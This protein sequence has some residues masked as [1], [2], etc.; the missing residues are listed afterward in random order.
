MR[1]IEDFGRAIELDPKFAEAYYNRGRAYHAIQ[2]Y[3]RAIEEYG[4]G[5]ELDPEF[6]EV[7]HNRGLAY[8]ELQDYERAIED[9]GCIM[10]FANNA[11]TI[12]LRGTTFCPTCSSE[13]PEGFLSSTVDF[14]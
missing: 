14:G 13:L 5:I 10:H 11:E 7:S 3:E 1:A 2:H 4:H 8:Y 12:D 6:A 9:F